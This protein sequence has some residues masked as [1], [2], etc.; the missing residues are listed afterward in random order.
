[1]LKLKNM[2][3]Y[4]EEKRIENEEDRDIN[5]LLKKVNEVI[6][7]NKLPIVTGIDQ[8][9]NGIIN[10]E[11]FDCITFIH[12]DFANKYYK[13][14]LAYSMDK[15]SVV[16]F[17]YGESKNLKK[18]EKRNRAKN[19]AKAGF[20]GALNS[21]GGSYDQALGINNVI[22]GAIGGIMSLGGSKKKQE[23]ENV[24]YEQISV[25]LDSIV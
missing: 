25:L 4:L 12:R 3:L 9:K 11:I 10:I 18:L 17:N 16:V 13:F 20:S 2:N 19:N 23:A 22:S 14:A 1:M 24:Y 8:I 21:K 5:K 15:H 6:N 7:Q